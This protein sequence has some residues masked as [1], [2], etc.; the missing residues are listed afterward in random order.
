VYLT[1][2][3]NGPIDSVESFLSTFGRLAGHIEHIAENRVI[4]DVVVPLH[5]AIGI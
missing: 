1:V 5:Q 2:R 3:K 4:P